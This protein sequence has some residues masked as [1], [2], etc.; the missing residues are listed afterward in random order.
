MRKWIGKRLKC[1]ICSCTSV[2]D[3]KWRATSKEI[4]FCLIEMKDKFVK[5]YLSSDKSWT[6]GGFRI[7]S[8]KLE[9]NLIFGKTRH[10]AR[11]FSIGKNQKKKSSINI[12]ICFLK[13]ARSF[14]NF[15][16][17]T[18]SH[19][20]HNLRHEETEGEIRLIVWR[21]RERIVD[22]NNADFRGEV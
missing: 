22:K 6:F 2:K 8:I 17:C 5:K 10:T 20:C 3:E 12:L 19:P 13:Q 16:I 18:N 7:R 14:G 11:F 15:I 4:S 21:R 9:L 1:W